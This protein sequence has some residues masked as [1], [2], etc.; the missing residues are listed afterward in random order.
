MHCIMSVQQVRLESTAEPLK[1]R[2]G[3]NDVEWM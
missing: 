1:R 2:H 3:S